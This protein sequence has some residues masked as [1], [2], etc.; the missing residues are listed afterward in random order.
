MKIAGI[1]QVKKSEVLSVLTP[2]GKTSIKDGSMSLEEAAD[3]YKV[4]QVKKESNWGSFDGTFSASYKRIPDDPKDILT[5]AQ[6]GSLVDAFR[7][8]YEDGINS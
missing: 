4:E 1:G 5:P 2:A 3:L 6:L 7:K 8:C